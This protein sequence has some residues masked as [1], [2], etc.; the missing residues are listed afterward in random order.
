MSPYDEC[1]AVMM[2][3]GKHAAERNYANSPG[4]LGGRGRGRKRE[5]APL[6]RPF[7][8]SIEWLVETAVFVATRAFAPFDFFGAPVGCACPAI[9]GIGASVG[10]LR[11]I[12]KHD[13]FRC[14]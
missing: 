5:R 7:G 2:A 11:Q 14:G 8:V 13:H 12:G 4:R 9:C 1:D 3:G 6:R 10:D